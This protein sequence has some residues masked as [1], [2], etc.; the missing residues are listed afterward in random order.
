MTTAGTLRTNQRGAKERQIAYWPAAN[1]EARVNQSAKRKETCLYVTSRH[2]CR[3]GQAGRD[4]KGGE[5][6]NQ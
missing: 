1:V 3:D 2:G 6:T 5:E 4:Q